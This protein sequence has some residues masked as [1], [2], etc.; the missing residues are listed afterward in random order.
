[1]DKVQKYNSFST[2]TPSSESYREPSCFENPV[3]LQH[4]TSLGSTST[5]EARCSH[6][7]E[8]NE[9]QEVQEALDTKFGGYDYGS[10]F[11]ILNSKCI[12]TK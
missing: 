4:S 11:C 1:M 10:V 3:D 12:V 7:Q 9:G 6:L 2:N 5:C 8:E